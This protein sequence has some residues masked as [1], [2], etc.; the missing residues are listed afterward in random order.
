M[1][2][3]VLTPQQVIENT[4]AQY[5][6][7]WNANQDHIVLSETYGNHTFKD[8]SKCWT[9]NFGQG[10]VG[11]SY[12]KHETII[13]E[14]AT[15]DDSM[16][17]RKE[18]AEKCGINT[19]IF[20][21]QDDGSVLEIGFSQKLKDLPKNWWIVKTMSMHRNIHE[22][23]VVVT[24]NVYRIRTPSP[25]CF[26]TYRTHQL[27]SPPTSTKIIQ[28]LPMVPIALPISPVCAQFFEVVTTD[29]KPEKVGELSDGSIGHPL[30][31]NGACKYAGRKGCKFGASC[32]RCH[33]CFWTRASERKVAKQSKAYSR[34]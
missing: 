23:N 15:P 30:A 28:L 34:W 24:D 29:T 10:C 5:G 18:L 22:G 7:V 1:A 33:L 14:S 6:I 17:L 25:P 8:L 19:V 21:P 11:Q 2:M 3:C 12:A 13:V 31:C 9:F 20:S 26:S 32:E 4:M 16:F 27:M